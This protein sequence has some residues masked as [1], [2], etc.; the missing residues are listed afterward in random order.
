MQLEIQPVRC[1]LRP[2]AKNQ[3]KDLEGSAGHV[4]ALPTDKETIVEPDKEVARPGHLHV[5]SVKLRVIIP[6]HAASVQR[7][8]PGDIVIHRQG[9]V[10]RD[11]DRNS[12]IRDHHRNQRKMLTTRL[13]MSTTSYVPHQNNIRIH[14]V[15]NIT[16]SK[17]NG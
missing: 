3:Y 9:L 7:V 4:V 1:R 2:I 8:V 6:S 5:P 13:V 17:D 14:H 11:G 15:L 10:H 12:A 16:S